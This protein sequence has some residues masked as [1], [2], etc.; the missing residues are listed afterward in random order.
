GETDAL[1]PAERD[2]PSDFELWPSIDYATGESWSAVAQGYYKDIESAIRP[3]EVAALL[4]GT[5]RVKGPEL[6]HRVLAKV[7]QKV[8]YIVLKFGSS[9]L[10]PQPAGET[11][12]SGYGDC[13]D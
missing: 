4:Q 3:G 2:L 13:K 10:I 9:A 7:H 5:A 12:K 1:E 11:L 8:R 6:L